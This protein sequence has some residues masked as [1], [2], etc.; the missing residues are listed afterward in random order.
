MAFFL[1]SLPD[2]G[3]PSHDTDSRARGQTYLSL[4]TAYT[5]NVHYLQIY[6]FKCSISQNKS[7]IN[8]FF[9]AKPSLLTLLLLLLFS[10]V[11]N[12]KLPN[13]CAF[14]EIRKTIKTP[15]KRRP[16]T[17]VI[18]SSQ[19]STTLSFLFDFFYS[20]RPINN[21]SDIQGRSSWFEPVLS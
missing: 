10:V 15:Q 20:L 19:V 18:R 12:V 5:L 21:L 4:H 17:S 2:E 9:S 8:G 13:S 16:Q 3:A 1:L 14:P 11:C 7:P 6:Y